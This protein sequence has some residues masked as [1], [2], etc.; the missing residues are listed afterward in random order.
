MVLV[1]MKTSSDVGYSSSFNRRW[2]DEARLEISLQY[3]TCIANFFAMLIMLRF[4]ISY[5]G[6]KVTLLMLNPTESNAMELSRT[7]QVSKRIT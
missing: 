1:S 3:S 4:A 6:L 5:F 7:R 2:K